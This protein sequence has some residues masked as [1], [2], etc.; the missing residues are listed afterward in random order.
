MKKI[1]AVVLVLAVFLIVGA[2]YYFGRSSVNPSKNESPNTAMAET[3]SDA[4]CTR[5][6]RLENAPQYDRA[7]S[8]IEQKYNLWEESGEGFGSWYFFPPKLVNCI[9]VIEGDVKGSTGAEG[10]FEINTEDIK[11]DYFPV[12]VD[13]SY[14][15]V[16]DLV[17]SLILI[18]EI[19]HVQ[20]YIDS[21]NGKDEL[22]CIDKEVEAFYASWK[23]YGIMNS[24]EWKSITMRLENDEDLHPQLQII[25][26][27]K[28][29]TLENFEKDRQMCLYGSGKD[30]ESCIDNSRK[31]EIKEMLL[32]DDFYKKQCSI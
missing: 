22:S 24:E 25:G 7:L 14:S 6:T 10:F 29:K 4:P 26:A 13:R 23:F 32:Q 8:I 16:D 28:D 18:H 20:Q 21:T 5:T 12:T 30:D 17:N 15:F 31:A 11:Q 1:S 2:A 27:I 9:K 3:N 19:T